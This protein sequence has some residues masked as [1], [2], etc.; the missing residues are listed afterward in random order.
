MSILKPEITFSDYNIFLSKI[1]QFYSKFLPRKESHR[2]CITEAQPS[3]VH[4]T[5]KKGRKAKMERIRN[6]A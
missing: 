2:I 3:S 1:F 5:N 4:R 6:K